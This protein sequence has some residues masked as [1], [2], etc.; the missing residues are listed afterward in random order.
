MIN[1][2]RVEE[3]VEFIKFEKELFMDLH[4]DMDEEDYDNCLVN[5]DDTVQVL[6]SVLNE[7]GGV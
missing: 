6:C 7:M 2:E 5:F 1:K 3:L 4:A